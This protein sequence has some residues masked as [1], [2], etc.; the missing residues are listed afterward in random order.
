MQ[1]AVIIGFQNAKNWHKKWEDLTQKCESNTKTPGKT[2]SKSRKKLLK[3]SKTNDYTRKL[4][5]TGSR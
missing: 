1:R 5:R 2:T 3:K 4:G